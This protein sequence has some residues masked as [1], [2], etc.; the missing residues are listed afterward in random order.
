MKIHNV[1]RDSDL[2]GWTNI[3]NPD[4]DGRF[5]RLRQ[6]GSYLLVLSL[7]C[8][9]LV[10]SVAA[11]WGMREWTGS[12]DGNADY[13]P[14]QAPGYFAA[15]N[16]TPIPFDDGS[17]PSSNDHDTGAYADPYTPEE[18]KGAADSKIL[19]IE[20]DKLW[21]PFVLIFGIL[22]MFTTVIMKLHYDRKKKANDQNGEEDPFEREFKMYTEYGGKM[23]ISKKVEQEAA[24]M[25]GFLKRHMGEYNLFLR[26][27]HKNREK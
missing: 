26:T 3:Y 27:F 9:F 15:E 17:A 22:L 13:L 12:N 16:A 7:I 21:I 24:R 20:R 11:F 1:R 10:L 6:A 25:E 18:V 5:M 19:G 8:V 4:W 14:D 2:N 23:L